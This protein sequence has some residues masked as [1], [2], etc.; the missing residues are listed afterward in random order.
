LPR[1]EE[2]PLSTE[3]VL[4][5]DRYPADGPVRLRFTDS[6]S[7]QFEDTLGELEAAVLLAA[8]RGAQQAS[9]DLPLGWGGDRYRVYPTPDGPALVWYSVWDGGPQRDRFLGTAR[10]GFG[11]LGRTGYRVELIPLAIEG[12]AGIRVVHAPEAWARWGDQSAVALIPQ[13]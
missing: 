10:E 12:R 9:L 1:R 2:L 6:T 5:P 8:F 11:R 4:H 13:E 3:Q 7:A